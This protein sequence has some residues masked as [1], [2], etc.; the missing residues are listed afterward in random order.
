[1]IFK[2]K[3]VKGNFIVVTALMTEEIVSKRWRL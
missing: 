3:L 2:N 1:M